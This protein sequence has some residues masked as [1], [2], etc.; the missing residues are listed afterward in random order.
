VDIFATS[1]YHQIARY[2]TLNLHDRNAAGADSFKISW[3]D[4]VRPYINPPWSLVGLVLTKIANEGVTAMVGISDWINAPWYPLWNQLLVRSTV[5]IGPIYLNT[6]DIL[7]PLPTSA[8][9]RG[10][11][12]SSLTPRA[13]VLVQHSSSLQKTRTAR[14]CRRCAFISG[15]YLTFNTFNCERELNSKP[16]LQTTPRA[17]KGKPYETRRPP[18]LLLLLSSLENRDFNAR[19]LILASD[20]VWS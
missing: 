12:R 19:I 3:T 10:C 9:V 15:M 14:D 18:L 1:A 16:F 8:F 20:S 6:D 11:C 13:L 4:E 7:R 2:Y 17:Y 5:L